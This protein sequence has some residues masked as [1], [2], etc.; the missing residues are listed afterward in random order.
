MY[1][2]CE[3]R[4]SCRA[5]PMEFLLAEIGLAQSALMPP[6]NR[7]GG[8]AT[9]A[10]VTSAVIF[11]CLCSGGM[12]IVN[13][14]TMHHIPLP[15]LAT[16]CQFSTARA[17]R[18]RSRRLR[19]S[20]ARPA[21][22]GRLRVAEGQALPRVRHVLH[23][24][25]VDQHEGAFDRERRD[26]DRCALVHTVCRLRPGL[27]V[28]RPCPAQPALAALAPSHHRRR[29]LLH[30]HRPRVP[31]EWLGRLL[32]GPHLVGGARRPADVRQVPRD[33]D[34]VALA[35]DARPVHEHILGDPG[36]HR[37]HP[38]RRALGVAPQPHRAH[39]HRVSRARRRAPARPPQPS[40][41]P[42]PTTKPGSRRTARAPPPALAVGEPRP[43]TAAVARLRAG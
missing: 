12:L 20:A 28:L 10:N 17:R 2:A 5:P 19:W 24:W 16:V 21:R 35:L 1:R 32:L 41:H 29:R 37:R 6:A 11:Y 22:D 4:R 8:E 18:G 42:L 9:V 38:L 15:A 39:A 26:G 33:R 13:K 25:H 31:G 40:H 7:V 14:L 3:A 27:R 36:A 23:D 34:Q 30:S 43:T